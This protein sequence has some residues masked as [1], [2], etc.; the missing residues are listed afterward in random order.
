MNS[1]A[2]FGESGALSHRGLRPHSTGASAAL[3]PTLCLAALA[4]VALFLLLAQPAFAATTQTFTNAGDI[5]INDNANASPYPSTT[6]VTQ[7]DPALITRVEVKLSGFSHTSPHDVDILLVGPRGQRVILMS[8]AGGNVSASNINLTFSATGATAIPDESAL[9]TGT[10]RPANYG[11][12]ADGDL[13]DNFPGPGPGTLFNE[14]ANLGVFNETDPNGDWNL[15]VVD[16]TS[17]DP[18]SI[19]GGWSLSLTV[20]TVFTVNSTDDPGDG[21]CDANNC[22]L[23][24]ALHPE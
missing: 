22:T 18:G 7:N 21:V 10:Y 1:P 9:S 24:E 17:N 20:P 16:D 4:V 19:S 3:P 12:S 11:S 14:G 6:N 2:T 23:R 5:E 8:D 15:Y 13:N